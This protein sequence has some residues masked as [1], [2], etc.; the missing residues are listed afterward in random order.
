MPAAEADH[1]RTGRSGSSA[2]ENRIAEVAVAPDKAIAP[3]EEAADAGTA[4]APVAAAVADHAVH[5][6]RE[7]AAAGAVAADK[8]IRAA[9]TIDG[10]KAAPP[11]GLAGRLAAAAEARIDGDIV[12]PWNRVQLHH[13]HP[14][15]CQGAEWNLGRAEGWG[16]VLRQYQRSPVEVRDLESE[17]ELEQVEAQ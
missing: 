3:A 8:V 14:G 4:V 7:V 12:L 6:P 16:Y 5:S 10:G 13:F 17:R 1:S 15:R 9:G 11:A 2:C